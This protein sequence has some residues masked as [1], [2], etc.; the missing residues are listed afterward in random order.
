MYK[1]VEVEIKIKYI[2]KRNVTRTLV[3]VE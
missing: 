2:K 3:N 1:L